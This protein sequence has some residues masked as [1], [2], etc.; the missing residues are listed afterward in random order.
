MKKGSKRYYQNKILG[1]IIT[2]LTDVNSINTTYKSIDSDVELPKGCSRQIKQKGSLEAEP[3]NFGTLRAQVSVKN[4]F[5]SGKVSIGPFALNSTSHQLTTHYDVKFRPTIVTENT[6]IKGFTRLLDE[7]GNFISAWLSGYISGAVDN[8][9]DPFLASLNTNQFTYN[10]LNL[11]LRN[12]FGETAVWFCAQPIIRDMSAANERSKSQYAKDMSYK[13]SGYSRKEYAIIQAV[14]QYVPETAITPQQMKKWT[15][16]TAK[17]DQWDRVNVINWVN[18]HKELLREFATNPTLQRIT[19]NGVDYSRDYVQQQV[20][21]AWKSLEKY[22]TALGSLVQHTKIDTRKHGKSI[23]EINRYLDGYNKI[24]HPD[25]PS[26]SIWDVQGL[27]DF[28]RRTWLEQ[29]TNAAIQLPSR[30]LGRYTFSANPQFISAVLGFA[31]QLT[32]PGQEIS[33]DVVN[34]ISRHLQTAVKSQYFV[35]FVADNLVAR[36]TEGRPTETADQHIRNLFVGPRSISRRLT[37]LKLAIEMNPAYKRLASNGLIRQLYSITEEDPKVLHD[38]LTELPAF[39]T[40]LDSVDSSKINSD[41]LIDGWEDLLKDEDKYVRAFAQDLIIYAFMTSGEFKGW[42]KLFKYVPAS[43]ITGEINPDYTSYAT[44]IENILS[45][46]YDYRK[47]FDDIAANCFGDI[48]IVESVP[49]VNKDKSS[50]F[51]DANTVCKIG[52]PIDVSEMDSTKPYILVKQDMNG[53]NTDAYNLYKLIGFKFESEDSVAPVYIRMK[54][55]GYSRKNNNIYEYGWDFQFRGNENRVMNENYDIEQAVHRISGNDINDAS[56]AASVQA[57]YLE[58]A[59]PHI[60]EAESPQKE[61]QEIPTPDWEYLED[62]GYSGADED[63]ALL[64][65]SGEGQSSSKEHEQC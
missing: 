11:L 17:T 16:S 20:F 62:S 2:L 48:S 35:D 64:N 36:D 55:R 28:A 5:I 34:K 21:F 22:A 40:V 9:K 24:F 31:E 3:Y 47:H 15:T 49:V 8:A 44:Y 18:T 50:N 27:Q 63:F 42:S 46:G 29:K 39:I 37:G 38:E 13:N 25:D 14:K 1:N 57:R 45:G 65:E 51:I 41:A 10:M 60:E 4:D 26:K 61:Q 59:K 19:I 23:I 56:T 6:P 32:E 52:R 12:G 7:D 53:R 30:I 58:L 54:K 33:M 43:W